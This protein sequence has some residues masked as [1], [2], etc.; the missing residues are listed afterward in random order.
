M[1]YPSFD[2][3]EK[4]HRRVGEADRAS[5]RTDVTGLNGL[6]PG[7]LGSALPQEVALVLL[8]LKDALLVD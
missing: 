7:T 4:T 2:F 5:H 6:V 3:S 8:N 1:S